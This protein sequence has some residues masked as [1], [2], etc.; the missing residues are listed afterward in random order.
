MVN[1]LRVALP[2]VEVLATAA[3]ARAVEEARQ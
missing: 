1:H 2:R 3:L